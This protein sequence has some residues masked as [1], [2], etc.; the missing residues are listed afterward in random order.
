MTAM[1]S[2]CCL[3]CCSLS[4][5]SPSLPGKILTDSVSLSEYNILE[6]NFVV[7]MVSRAKMVTKPAEV[8]ERELLVS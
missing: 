3:V 7:V 2:L 5:L 8:R 1:S 6:S 4:V